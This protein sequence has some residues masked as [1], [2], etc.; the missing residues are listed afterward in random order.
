MPA[1]T[2]L[3]LSSYFMC[4]LARLAYFDNTDFLFKLTN[5]LQ[6]PQLES[7]LP[8]FKEKRNSFI[9]N[10]LQITNKVNHINYS[11]TPPTRQN[12]NVKYICISTS[13]YSSVYLVAIKD[14][15]SIFVCFRGTYSPKSASSW[16]KI[17]SSIPLLPCPSLQNKDGYMIGIFKIVAEIFYTIS[18]SIDYL[19]ST[20][21][22]NPDYSLFATGHSLG[23][24]A[25]F[26]FSFLFLKHNLKNKITC[27][28][29]GAPR[30]LNGPSIEKINTFI[31]E[32][33]LVFQR[34]VTNGDFLANLP[35]LYKHQSSVRTY[36]HPDEYNNTQTQKESNPLVLFCQTNKRTRR[37]KCS[38]NKTTRTKMSLSS[39]S[40]YLGIQYT[41]AANGKTNFE[42][43]IKRNE[44]Q[45]S[46]CRIIVG[47]NNKPFSISFFNLKQAKGID[48]EEETFFNKLKKHVVSDFKHQDI[49]MNLSVLKHIIKS[50]NHTDD[51]QTL[52]PLQFNTLIPIH[53]N[54]THPP[55]NQIYCLEG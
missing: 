9:R 50:G 33:R 35:P 14:M 24:A 19:A 12:K 31:S 1:E 16:A 41:N 39:H 20:F 10:R 3:L 27:V 26:L 23:G 5:I 25:S 30:V 44:F 2:E 17:R 51:L 45:D 28:T 8:A 42:K 7:Q 49:F 29:F 15:N 37:I 4:I 6:I 53:K 52:N 43:E 40:N 32:K 21:L 18:S 48:K 38:K 47:G 36:Y 11:Q 13:N 22:T 46:I 34:F 54:K 55:Q